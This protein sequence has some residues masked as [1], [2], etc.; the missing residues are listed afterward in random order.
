MLKLALLIVK[1]PTSLRLGLPKM[2]AMSG[3]M[4]PVTNASIDCG[5]RGA[6]DD[7]D[8]EV[9]DV[10]SHDEVAESL[11]HGA[12]LRVVPPI[13]VRHDPSDACR[14]RCS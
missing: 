13:D 2:A 8:G 7:G 4:S 12:Y 10:A 14:K 9:E 3:L 6:D 1:V 5:E 11:E